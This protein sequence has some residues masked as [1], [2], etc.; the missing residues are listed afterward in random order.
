MGRARHSRPDHRLRPSLEPTRRDCR[1]PVRL[2]AEDRYQQVLQLAS[3][4]WPAQRTQRLDS[5]RPL[6]RTLGKESDPR[7]LRPK[8]IRRLSS[9]DVHDAGSKHC[10]RQPV[11][12]MAGSQPGWLTSTLEQA[13]V[14]KRDRIP[15]TPS[16]SR[17]L[18][19][20]RFPH[21][22]CGNV[23]LPLQCLGWSQPLYRAL[24]TARID[25]GIGSR[26]DSAKG[27]RE[28]PGCF[29]A[30]HLR[31]WSPIHCQGLQRIHPH[32]RHDARQDIAVLPSVQRQN[33]ALASNRQTR[34]HS[35]RSATD[36]RRCPQTLGYIHRAIQH[37]SLA[38]CDRLCH[39][40]GQTEP[41]RNRDFCR[42]RPQI[43]RSPAKTPTTPLCFLIRRNYSTIMTDSPIHAEPRQ[44]SRFNLNSAI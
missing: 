34:M 24:G 6:V 44:A 25:E 42:Q 21:Q 30:H 26:T 17:A 29:A 15:A 22:H 40:A 39:T 11:Q 36:A 41:T 18:A 37:R 28:V 4:L 19:R 20:R 2:M 9:A 33:R 16:A 13:T 32:L 23:L 27:T 12:H 5:S 1:S 31:Q 35:S 38:Q 8:P 14:V 10:R 7:F 3:A 43:G